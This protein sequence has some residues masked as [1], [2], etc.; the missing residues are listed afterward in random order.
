MDYKLVI[1][2][3]ADE[4]LDNLVLLKISSYFSQ[5]EVLLVELYC[6]GS[7]CIG[8]IGRGSNGFLCF[9]AVSV[10]AHIPSLFKQKR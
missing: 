10:E 3:H 7:F 5:Y 1:S 8:C 9:V 4:L 2:E 6:I